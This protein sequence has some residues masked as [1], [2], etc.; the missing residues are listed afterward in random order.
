MKTR[1]DSERHK[2]DIHLETSWIIRC[3]E[4]A[5]TNG[6]SSQE[7]YMY[8]IYKTDIMDSFFGDTKNKHFISRNYAA[9][10]YE[11]RF[12]SLE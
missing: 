3:E 2:Y 4:F 6:L 1:A 5:V 8:L 11:Q 12:L 10:C 7:T 9:L